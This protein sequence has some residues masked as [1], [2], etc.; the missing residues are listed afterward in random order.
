MEI[1]TIIGIENVDADQWH[2]LTEG[3]PYTTVE[4]YRFGQAVVKKKGYYLIVTHNGEA[5]AGA[6]L[7]VVPQL[8]QS[9]GNNI[10]DRFLR[11]YFA[12]NPQLIMQ[13]PYGTNHKGLFLP[14]DKALAQQALKLILQASKR[15]LKQ[16]GG[17]FLIMDYLEPDDLSYDWQDCL[18]LDGFMEESTKLALPYETYDEYKLAMKAIKQRNWK[19]IKHNTRY[20]HDAGIVVT[21]TKE[22]PDKTIVIKLRHEQMEKYD[23]D[24]EGVFTDALYDCVLM[25]DS[26][27]WLIAEQNGHVVAVECILYDK[28]TGTYAPTLFGRDQS[29]DYTYFLMYYRAIETAIETLN[30]KIMIGDSRAEHVKVR[31]G[32][33]A[34]KRNNIVVY[35]RSRIA[36]WLLKR[37]VNMVSYEDPTAD[38]P[39]T[40]PETK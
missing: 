40:L 4:W 37:I 27:S 23:I 19:N 24:T 39:D 35:P 25:L 26:T 8:L 7:R 20:A 34:D 29:V 38:I 12:H 22:A 31:L 11:W 16:V 13:S 2:T 21:H 17:S 6:S 28:R 1:Q 30:A 36:R 3:H 5:I 14:P 32:F 33:V 10:L 15:V 9:T 18:V